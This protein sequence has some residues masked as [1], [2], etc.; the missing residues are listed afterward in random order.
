MPLALGRMKFTPDAMAQLIAEGPE[1]RAAYF[2]R[3]LE[4]RGG[5]L[6][7][8]YFAESS[9]FHIVTICDL[10]EAMRANA[11]ASIA[12]WAANWSAGMAEQLD[13]TWLATPK[14]MAAASK[15]IGRVAAPGG[16]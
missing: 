10:P 5:K 8:Y 12:T 4:E 6:L 14:E 7:G 15:A 11:A 1:E 3:W 9:E 16:E 2:G 13:V